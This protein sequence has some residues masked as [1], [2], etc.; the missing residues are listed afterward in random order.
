M[1][2]II[3]SRSTAPTARSSSNC[4]RSEVFDQQAP[5]RAASIRID[6]V[7]YSQEELRDGCIARR[8]APGSLHGHHATLLP[9]MARDSISGLSVDHT[10]SIIY[11]ESSTRP[12]RTWTIGSRLSRTH[13]ISPQEPLTTRA[14]DACRFVIPPWRV[15]LL[16][17]TH[18][19][20]RPE[21]AAPGLRPS[22]T[23]PVSAS[24]FDTFATIC[25]PAKYHALTHLSRLIASTLLTRNIIRPLLCPKNPRKS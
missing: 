12:N 24:S 11:E 19:S 9:K 16:A 22:R 8:N 1:R 25:G 15:R 14:R 2:T 20:P 4:T 18:S 23:R 7:E 3:G 6:L 10:G 13:R 5:W 17:L 21:M